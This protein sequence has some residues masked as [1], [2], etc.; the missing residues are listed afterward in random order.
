[1]AIFIIGGTFTLAG[2]V[3]TSYIKAS[4]ARVVAVLVIGLVFLAIF[5]V[6]ETICEKTF[7]IRYALCP[8]RVFTR[9][10]G[11]DMTA[12]WVVM[13]VSTPARSRVVF[14]C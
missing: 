4:D 7:N 11:R 1:M 3:M 2:I 13:F 6:W 9:N 5:G 12:P 14:C 8:Q 10:K